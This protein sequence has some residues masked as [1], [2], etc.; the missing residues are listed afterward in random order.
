MKKGSPHAAL[1]LAFVLI[2]GPRHSY[3]KGHIL[4]TSVIMNC[5]ECR[6]IY[7]LIPDVRE[8]KIEIAQIINQVKVLGTAFD[9][10]GRFRI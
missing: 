9:G 5:S 1:L 6:T 2:K 4:D 7:W 10:F 8:T 3:K